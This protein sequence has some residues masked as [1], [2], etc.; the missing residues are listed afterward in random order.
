MKYNFDLFPQ[1]YNSRIKKAVIAAIDRPTI[2]SELAGNIAEKLK[3]DKTPR[4]TAH[5]NALEKLYV[6]KTLT[7]KLKKSRPGRVYAL[8]D[9]G[10]KI[11]RLI[12]GKDNTSYIYYEPEKFNWHSYGWC[13]TGTQ[14][15]SIISILEKKPLRPIE[16]KH[17]IREKYK[18]RNNAWG[19]TFQNLN[20]ILQLMVKRKIVSVKE[21]QAK[22]K[23]K[24]IKKYKLTKKGMEIQSLIL[25]PRIN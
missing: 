25:L 7:P 5:I 6:L 1:I 12:C 22:K 21:E 10:K 8:T 17:N 14:K 19:I 24:P 2:L 9:K 3:L 18:N 20:D 4:I 16:I 23:K 13:L 15:K 11:K